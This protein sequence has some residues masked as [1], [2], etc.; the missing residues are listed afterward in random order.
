MKTQVFM[1]CGDIGT[2]FIGRACGLYHSLDNKRERVTFSRSIEKG[3]SKILEVKIFKP[4]IITVLIANEG[5][6]FF[7][8]PSPPRRA[9]ARKAATKEG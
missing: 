3:L 1:R 2:V 9:E 8:C 7:R 6:P 4:L 5:S